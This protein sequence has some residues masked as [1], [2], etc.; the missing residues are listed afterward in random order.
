MTFSSSSHEA[1]CQSSAGG[2]ATAA[3]LYEAYDVAVRSNGDVIISDPNNH[4]IRMVGWYE[5]DG[6]SICLSMQALVGTDELVM[7]L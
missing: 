7:H 6:G 3:Q 4:A 2:L 1:L 5:L